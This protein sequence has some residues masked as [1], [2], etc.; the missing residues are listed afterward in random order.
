[1]VLGSNRDHFNVPMILLWSIF[2]VLLD[3]CPCGYVFAEQANTVTHGRPKRKQE[4]N[5]QKMGEVVVVVTVVIAIV[6]T[7]F[8]PLIAYWTLCG[9][10]SSIGDYQRSIG[11][12]HMKI[13]NL[14]V[15]QQT[16]NGIVQ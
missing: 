13:S 9:Q 16:L 4:E 14:F 11:S 2:V 12:L 10:H 7:I 8:K 1:M 6:I 5:C 15:D 3:C